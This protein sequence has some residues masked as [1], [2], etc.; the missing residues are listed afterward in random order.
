M[1]GAE[2]IEHIHDNLVTRVWPDIDPV[3]RGEH[4]DRNLIE[5]AVGRPF[6]TAFGQEIHPKVSDKA[7]ALFHSLIANHP[8]HNGNKR[9]AVLALDLF[10]AAN[11]YFCMLT[12]EPMYKLAE[13]TASYKERGLTHE[14]SLEELRS[15][16][17]GKIFPLK[18]LRQVAEK[19]G[20]QDIK[21][22]YVTFSKARRKIRRDPR[23]Q[24]LR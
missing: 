1:L 17:D 3:G 10:C 22:L 14:E 20:N 4:R 19:G 2:Y 16:L 13:R 24:L 23:N 7:I 18:T 12:N 9:T 5:S 21:D 6:Q 8:F 15:A 11:G